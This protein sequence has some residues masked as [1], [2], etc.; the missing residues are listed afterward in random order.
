MSDLENIQKLTRIIQTNNNI[1]DYYISLNKK[2]NIL[3]EELKEKL[4]IQYE[5]IELL[6]KVSNESMNNFYLIAKNTT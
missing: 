4:K 3:E 6:N 2:I 5:S 1:I